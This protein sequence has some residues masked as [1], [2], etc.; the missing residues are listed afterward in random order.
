MHNL[1]NNMPRKKDF[2]KCYKLKAK[3]VFGCIKGL[4]HVNDNPES[5][6]NTLSGQ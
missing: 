6:D 3:N 4:N 5:K 1:I 2:K